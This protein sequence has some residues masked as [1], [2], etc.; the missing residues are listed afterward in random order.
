MEKIKHII[1]YKSQD[2]DKLR[3]LE[4]AITKLPWDS[5]VKNGLLEIKFNIKRELERR[6]TSKKV[7]VK[8]TAEWSGYTSSQKKDCAI[9][10]RKID[11]ALWDKMPKYFSHQFSDNTHNGWRAEMA[12]KDGGDSYNSYGSQVD[13]F[14]EDLIK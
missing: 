2:T 9:E 4:T 12:I 1:G 5:V 6:E 7:L 8:F 3:E 14:L 13:K 10:Y 11:R